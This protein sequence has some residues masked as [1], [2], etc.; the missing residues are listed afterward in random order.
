MYGWEPE[1]PSLSIER[2]R[3]RS[4]SVS[5]AANSTI[6][7]IGLLPVRYAWTDRRSILPTLHQNAQIILAIGSTV[8]GRT[9]FGRLE[10]S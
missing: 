7:G 4:F 5:D 3:I 6:R 8:L 9:G 2:E 1:P 10:T